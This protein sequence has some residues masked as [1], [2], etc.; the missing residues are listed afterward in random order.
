MSF[1]SSVIDTFREC[2]DQLGFG[3]GGSAEGATLH[4]EYCGE[5][6]RFPIVI[7][8]NDDATLVFVEVIVPLMVPE[9]FRPRMAE[10]VVRANDH[11]AVGCFELNMSRGQLSFRATI[12]IDNAPVHRD[13]ARS[14]VLHSLATADC[15]FPAFN[16][17]LYGDDLSAA[18]VIAEVEMRVVQ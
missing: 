1:M 2:L 7:R 13:Q 16:R 18:E 4:A 9:G 6:G 17:L 14:L 3:Y 5:A 10:A 12:P 8:V 11:L 15:Y